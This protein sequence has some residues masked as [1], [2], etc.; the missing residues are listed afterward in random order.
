MT[1]NTNMIKS[2]PHMISVIKVYW[3]FISQQLFHQSVYH[4]YIYIM[5][6]V[7]DLPKK[8]RSK[9]YHNKSIHVEIP[10]ETHP[11]PNIPRQL[12]IAGDL[13]VISLPLRRSRRLPKGAPTV[14]GGG[15]VSHH[16]LHHGHL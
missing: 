1:G 4:I 14:A 8:H 16:G 9:I 3:E 12:V 2:Y 10:R 15:E 13:L 7:G 5:G 6:I 11:I